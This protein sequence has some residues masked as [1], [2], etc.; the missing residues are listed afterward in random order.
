LRCEIRE[1]VDA[2]NSAALLAPVEKLIGREP[3][4][5]SLTP[6]RLSKLTIGLSTKCLGVLHLSKVITEV[7]GPL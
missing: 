1:G 7:A 2:I 4:A 5:L 3:R 6:A